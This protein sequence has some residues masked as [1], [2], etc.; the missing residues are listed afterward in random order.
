MWGGEQV[1]DRVEVSR[2]R[3][4]KRDRRWELGGGEVEKGASL[5]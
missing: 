5:G 4:G 2:R 1:G 3:A